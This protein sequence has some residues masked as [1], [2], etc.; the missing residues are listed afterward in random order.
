MKGGLSVLTL[1]CALMGACV[2][3][4]TPH[5]GADAG[6]GEDSLEGANATPPGTTDGVA[7]AT[8]GCAD[9]CGDAGPL[10]PDGKG[11]VDGEADGGGD[12]ADGGR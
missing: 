10:A 8:S 6:R 1:V 12:D 9:E 4:P 11:E 2:S 3:N 5:P 7:D